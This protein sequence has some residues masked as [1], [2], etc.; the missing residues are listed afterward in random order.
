V[1]SDEALVLLDVS[2][3]A[4]VPAFGM[5]RFSVAGRPDVRT[6]EAAFPAAGTLRFGYYLPGPNGSVDVRAAALFGTSCV[7]G[8][9]SAIADVKL[10][11][12]SPPV[13]LTVTR[14]AIIDPA[15]LDGGGDGSA[16][17]G[18]TDA[19]A[20]GATDAASDLHSDGSSEAPGDAAK[21]APQDVAG[22]A[23]ADATIEAG[24][25]TP[26]PPMCI[27]PARA[28]SSGSI[29]CGGRI[30]ATTVT[31]A[32][33]AVCCGTLDASCNTTNGEDCCGQLD[34][35]GSRCC[36]APK[37]RCS[38]SPNECCGGRACDTTLSTGS[39]RI[40][41]GNAGA[42][43]TDTANGTDCCRNLI[44]GSDRKCR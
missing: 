28:C 32:P 36:L 29:C 10:G 1:R 11:S 27:D 14:A 43:C 30:C 33:A 6:A 2:A 16:T 17:D 3:A 12:V 31:S 44:C 15:C 42:P 37:R 39:V 26:P 7:V 5:L 23:R 24:T 8:G 21:D 40:C 4:D 25:D 41:C 20:D 34:C 35:H 13:S 22:D 19:R 9:G 18:P 38:T